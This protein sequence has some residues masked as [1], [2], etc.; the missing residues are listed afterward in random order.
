MKDNYLKTDGALLGSTGDIQDPTVMLAAV[1]VSNQ[2]AGVAVTAAQSFGDLLAAR[3]QKRLMVKQAMEM[4]PLHYT[5]DDG[6]GMEEKVR[7]EELEK[8]A[9]ARMYPQMRPKFF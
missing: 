4:Q 7:M 2:L 9:R 5:D 1:V 8:R 3:R 6:R